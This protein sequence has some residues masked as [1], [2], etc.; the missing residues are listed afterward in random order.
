M[1]SEGS[2][3]STGGAFQGIVHFCGLFSEE[4]RRN[5]CHFGAGYETEYSASIETHT[6]TS[7]DGTHHKSIDIPKAESVDSSPGD[8]EN[9]YYNPTMVVHTAIPTRDTL[10]TEEYDEDY[11]EERT[12]EYRGICAEE[13]RLLRHSSWQRNA[14]VDREREEDYSIDSWA[15]D[16]YHENYAVETSVHEP[17]EDEPHEGFT[18]EELLNHQKR[19]DTNS[20]FA[21]ACG[22]GTCF[23]RLFTRENR[24]SIDINLPSSIEIRP[25]PP[26]TVSER[27]KHDNNYLTQDEFR[28]FKDPD[29]YARAMDGHALQISRE[30]IADILQMA[31]GADNLFMQ[32]RNIPEHQQKVANKFYDTTEFGKHAYN[33]DGTRRFHWEEKDEYGVYIDDQGHAREMKLDG[34]YYQLN[35]SISWLTTCME[36]MRQDISRIQT[37][38]VAEATRPSSIDGHQPASIDDDQPH[39]YPMKSQPDSCTRAEIDQ[40]IEV[41]YRTLETAEERLDRRCDDI[42]FPMDLTMSSL[43]FQTEAIQREIVEIQSQKDTH[44]CFCGGLDI[45]FVVTVSDPNTSRVRARSLRSDQLVRWLLRGNLVRVFLRFFVNVFSPQDSS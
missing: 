17:G 31:N 19:S 4:L 9:D 27:A 8:W 33:C 18:T 41:I 45:N 25:K 13:D 5:A 16:R 23:Y 20:L 39:S 6:A 26:S 43:T 11:K 32:Q 40:L 29:G 7:I 30:D 24:P 15:D 28:I 2:S 37:Q 22:R 14:T 21:E 12:T 1:Y 3:G 44:T 36:E 38:H 10:H 34:V 42:Y 35:D